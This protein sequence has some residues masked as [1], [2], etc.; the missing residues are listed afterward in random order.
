M[1]GQRPL[2]YEK[3][4]VVVGGGPAGSTIATLLADRGWSVALVERERHPRF[5]IGESLLPMNLP[6]FERLG[7]LDQVAAIGV[8]KNGADFV[9][10]ASRSPISYPF[11]HALGD[12]PGHAYQVHRAELDELLFRHAE[13]RG[14]E[15]HEGIAIRRIAVDEAGVEAEGVDEERSPVR[16][17]GRYLV[18]ASGHGTLVGRQLGIAKRKPRRK[19]AALFAHFNNV[20]VQSSGEPGNIIVHRITGGWAWLIPLTGGVTSVGVVCEPEALTC[21]SDRAETRL[22]EMLV[23]RA[24]SWWATRRASSTPSSRRGC[25]SP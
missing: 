18:D 20:H 7:V 2:T 17:T 22:R 21:P 24:G 13:S 12:S 5:H 9:T 15:G 8:K 4:V 11:A 1:G 25:S 19:S 16:F 10:A 14:V 23:A 6:I 3:D